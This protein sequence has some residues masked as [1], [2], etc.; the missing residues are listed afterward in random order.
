MATKVA[1]MTKYEPLKMIETTGEQSVPC[2]K[3]LSN[4]G[5]FQPSFPSFLQGFFHEEV[6]GLGKDG[7]GGDDRKSLF[8]GFA[9][10]LYVAQKIGDPKIGEPG[11]LR[12]QQLT[13]A[14]DGQVLLGYFET[15]RGLFH[16]PQA[17]HGIVRL[18]ILSDEQALGRVLS[19]AHPAAEL[20][21]LGEAKSFGMLDDHDRGVGDVD[22]DLD[23]NGGNENVNPPGL[24]V[25]H[26]RF[27]LLALYPSMD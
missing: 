15:I 22:A 26:D 1:Q 27:F 17:P 16:C 6:I 3:I 14:A 23:D 12:S 24:E 7:V 11:L 19:A 25:G 18:A 10:K 9:Q 20:V 21:E 5:Q 13:R 8:A 2:P 4:H